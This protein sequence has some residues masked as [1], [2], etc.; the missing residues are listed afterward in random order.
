ML[1]GGVG[2]AKLAR[3]LA[4]L[5]DVQ[6]TVIVNVGDDDRIYGLSISPDI[7]TVIYTM[8]GREG[9]H[10]WGLADD[11]FVAMDALD[12]LP[13]EATFRIGDRDLAT[14]LFRTDRLLAGWSLTWVTTALAS[15]FGVEATILPVTDDPIRTE[16]RIA[17]QGWI[18][19]QEYFVNRRHADDVLD[20]TFRGAGFSRP[21]PGVGEALAKADAIVIGP[22][23]PIL[24]VWPILAVPGVAD[25]IGNQRRVVAVSPLIE[26]KA[27]KGP[28]AQILDSLGFSSDTTGIAAAY[29]SLLSDLVVDESDFDHSPPFKTPRLHATD[30]RMPNTDESKRLARFLVDLLSAS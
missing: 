10:G 20:V 23:N 16:V 30:T 22:S 6:L 21:A 26:G 24:S 3:G 28:A 12:A 27:L 8:A 14:N 19:F 9:P 17:G 11:P 1:S 15:A 18:S 25:S 4:A 13:I 5:D 7:D 2:G 29:G